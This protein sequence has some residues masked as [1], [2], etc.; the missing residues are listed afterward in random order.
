MS[1][2][3]IIAL[4]LFGVVPVILATGF[5]TIGILETVKNPTALKGIKYELE[6]LNHKIS[7]IETRV[8]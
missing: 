6:C 1:P 8:Q 5:I 4:L 7:R 3:Y 2:G